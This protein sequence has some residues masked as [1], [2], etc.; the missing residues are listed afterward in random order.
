MSFGQLGDNTTTNRNAPAAVN[1][2]SGT[3]VLSGV[4]ARALSI[5]PV[6][7]HSLVIYVKPLP[8]VVTS[9]DIAS[10]STAGG[11]SVTITGTG[12]TGATGVTI[13]GVAATSVVVVN[14][15]TI[16]AVTPAGTA[17]TASVVVTTPSG[18]NAANTLYTYV[19]PLVATYTSATD[20][21]ETAAG[22]T[23]GGQDGGLHPQL[24]AGNGHEPDGGEQHR[25]GLRQRHVLTTW[26]TGPW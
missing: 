13:G 3:S 12:F 8:P 21:P 18:S 1:T 11:T 2:A 24:R 26:P 10:G 25:H 16:T 23:G 6:S 9:L 14:D 20:V 19:A 7:S 22:Y 5:G 15:T 17:G 4:S